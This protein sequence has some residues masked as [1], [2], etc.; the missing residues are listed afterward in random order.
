M[1]CSTPNCKQVALYKSGSK[2]FC[3]AHKAGA[4]KATS[5]ASL[6]EASFAAI[7]LGSRSEVSMAAGGSNRKAFRPK[8]PTRLR[9]LCDA[10]RASRLEISRELKAKATE[11]ELLLRSALEQNEITRGKFAFQECVRG[12][13]PDFLSLGFRLAI[14][15]NGEDH[16]SREGRLRDARRHKAFAQ[17]GLR[18]LEF[19][20]DE[21]MNGLDVVLD[22]IILACVGVD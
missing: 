4:L 12:Y 6:R 20:N 17:S 11:P 14:E 21:V 7:A 18:T 5:A 22:K 2:G 13:F 16:Y 15:C 8:L 3:K 10:A 19:R 9:G 1:K